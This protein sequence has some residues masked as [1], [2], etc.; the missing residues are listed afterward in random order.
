MTTDAEGVRNGDANLGPG[1]RD[2]GSAFVPQAV[3]AGHPD[4]VIRAGAFAKLDEIVGRHGSTVAW[5][6]LKDGF[7]L[8]DER[9]YFASQAEGIFKPRQM[10]SVLS[11]K[12]TIPRRGRHARYTDQSQLGGFL[13]GSVGILYDFKERDPSGLKERLLWEAYQLHIPFI[14][15]FGVAPSVYEVVAPVFI[16]NWDPVSRK[17]QLTT[18]LRELHDSPLAFPPSR[19]ERRY[20]TRQVSQRL[21]QRIFRERVLA[22]Y[23]RRCA[24]SR[25][26]LPE[27]IDAAHIVPDAD[28]NL[29]QPLVQNGIC[30]SKLH[31]TA[32]DLG[33]LAIDQDFTVHVAKRV[34]G[35][36]DGPMIEHLR[37]IDGRP[38]RRPDNHALWPDRDRLRQRYRE[39]VSTW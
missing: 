36:D 35:I 23:G 18:N 33:L 4:T 3:D 19:D 14:Y 9:I 5:G 21:H 31:H 29:G 25:L 6:V 15:F 22:A 28:E 2:F 27:L 17:V 24:L 38:M 11:I 10:R 12:T 20:A 16:E 39:T 37:A 32:F 1:L 13:M 34:V 26:R 7:R 30:M 8:G